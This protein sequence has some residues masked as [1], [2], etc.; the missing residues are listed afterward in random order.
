MMK[1]TKTT[2]S[3]QLDHNNQIEVSPFMDLLKSNNHLPEKVFFFD[4]TLRD[5][6]QTHGISFQLDEKL[7]IAKTLDELGIDVIEAGFPITSEGDY[8]AC[9]AIQNLG[10]QSEIMGLARLTQKDIDRVI[11]ADLDAIHVFIAT[12]DLHIQG[13]LQSSREQVLDR[14]EKYVQYASD[15]FSNVLFSAE[16]ATRSDLTYLIEANK[17]AVQ[18]GASRI[19][20]PDTV[21]TITPQAYG[22]VIRENAKALPANI[23]IAA[24]CHNDFGL[25]VA[26][27]IAAVENGAS[28][29]QC[30]LLGLGERAGNAS[31]EECAASIYALYQI[32]TNIDMKKIYPSAKLM[33]SLCGGMITIG[34]LTPLIGQNAFVHES[35]IHAHAMMQNARM[36]EP[37]SPEIIGI[38]RGDDLSSIINQSIKLGK[39]S[40]SHALRAKIEEIGLHP[41]ETQFSE[42]FANIK[43]VGDRGRKITD[44]DF[45]ALVKDVMHQIPEEEKFVHLKELT[46]LTG[47]VT[48]TATVRLEIRQNSHFVERIA[49]SIGNGPIDASILAIIKCYSKMNKIKLLTFNIEAITGGT[50][51][52]GHVTTEIMDLKT[53]QIVKTTATHEDVV[54]SSVLAMIKALNLLTKRRNLVESP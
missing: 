30:T 53:H 46:V 12:S 17:M 31:F 21:G 6:E 10:L 34:K 14:I 43:R 5:G 26:N 23:R 9:K 45:L 8:T 22:Y 51:A 32:P 29:I 27:S 42:I 7:L 52:L 33:E 47:S 18:S 40:G 36:Y 2:E 50:D 35:G 54:M 38:N 19:N 24:H 28:E 37:I 13:K 48:P 16:D 4:T 15:H 41:T 3:V 39:H 25:A 1:K 44:E 49:S 11:D 20:I